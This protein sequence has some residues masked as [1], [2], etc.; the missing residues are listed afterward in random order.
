M[1]V[2]NVTSVNISRQCMGNACPAWSGM[3]LFISIPNLV[4]STIPKIWIFFYHKMAAPAV[5][6][7]EFGVV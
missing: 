1:E 2:W 5:D 7:F 4:Q 6:D 3:T